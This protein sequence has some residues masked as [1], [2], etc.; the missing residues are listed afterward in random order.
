MGTDYIDTGITKRFRRGIWTRFIK[1]IKEYQLIQSGDRI[2]VCI[3][4]GKDSI[5]MA[6]CMQHLQKYSEIPFEVKFLVM[7]PGY[8]AVNR[9][10]IEDNC[11]KL[12]IPI[13][14]F[15]TDIFNSVVNV[16]NNPCYLCARMRRGYLY[17]N[18]KRL[19]CNKIALGHHYDDIVETILMSVLYGSQFQTMMPKVHSANFEGMELIRPMYLIREHDVI[20]WRDYNK[21]DFIQCACRM[22][23]EAEAAGD[24]I[25]TSK[26]AEIK[27][28]IKNLHEINPNVEKSIF[29]SVENVNLKTLVSYKK[30]GVVTHF[31]D[32]YDSEIPS[33]DEE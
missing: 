26:R 30:N 20:A 16:K 21:L 17:S 32:T 29:R 33:Y 15:E 12:G 23:E 2:A 18:A 6:K 10:K 22:T 11:A 5:L 8:N 28:L 31:L 27:Q 14:I 24:H 1:A 4:G 19:G 13:E 7:D 25:G 3:S 9:K